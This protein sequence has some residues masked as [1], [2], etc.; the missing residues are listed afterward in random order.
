MRFMARPIAIHND[1]V[2]L[3]RRW[4]VC[5]A[6]MIFLTL[7]VGGATRLTESGL[8]I[9]EWKPVSGT[10]PPLSDAAWQNEFTKYQATPQYR[11]RNRGMSLDE[12][13][14]IYWWEWAHRMLARVTGAVFLLPFVWLLWRGWIPPRLRVRLWAIFGGGAALGLVGWLMVASGLVGRTSVSQYWLAFH[15][16]LASTVYAAVL[17]T[18]RQLTPRP[19]KATLPRLRYAALA[20][21]A[22]VLCQ[23]YLGAL[24]AGLHAGLIYNT[25]PL[26]DGALLPEQARLWF[27]EPVWRNV[28]ENTLTVQ[29]DHRML[30][31][32]IWLAAILHFGDTWR[33]G[34]PLGSAAV[35]AVLVT[36]Q[37]LLGIV[38]LLDQAPIP[39]AFAHQAVAILVF[40]AA[41]AHAESLVQRA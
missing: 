28:F 27:I 41:L 33:V 3:V 21:A 34:A 39:L 14:T 18:A 6:A 36:L 40:T 17:W 38:T 24:V 5:V 4:L 15:L 32:A 20:I 7:M 22:M 23:I 35:L 12:F 37:A 11:E 2:H 13:K 10:L 19:A 31:Y 1:H 8:S 29:F 30:A 26:I 9:V 25:W 16:T